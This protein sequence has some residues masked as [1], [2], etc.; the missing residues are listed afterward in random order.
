MADVLERVIDFGSH[1]VIWIGPDSAEKDG[2]YTP[3][4]MLLH[5]AIEAADA[6]S[7]LLRHG[8]VDAMGLHI[9]SQ[10]EAT[11]NAFYILETDTERRGKAYRF[12]LLKAE[13]V[14][15]ERL[16]PST[17]KGAAASSKMKRDKVVGSANL[18]P[19]ANLLAAKRAQNRTFLDQSIYDE[20]RQEWDRQAA[21][22]KQKKPTWHSL[23]GGPTSV[24]EMADRLQLSS[25]YE[26][27][28]P[29]SEEVHASTAMRSVRRDSKTNRAR[30]RP[31][32]HPEL[33]SE[34]LDLCVALLMKLYS[35]V[36]ERFS[37]KETVEL[38]SKWY[39]ESVRAQYDDPKPFGTSD[40][41]REELVAEMSAAFLCGH[42]GIYPVVVANS[43][44][45]I[46][47]WLGILKQDKKLVIS[48]AGQAQRSADWIL[49]TTFDDTCEQVDDVSGQ[50]ASESLS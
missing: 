1:V 16:D 23:F 14:A 6:A 7:V 38:L 34:Y 32:R 49:G 12:G 31:M 37:S 18:T 24:A 30:F 28:R 21:N 48:A 29:L 22:K 33:A 46:S 42:A 15:L 25:F 4:L 8:C 26:F 35:E 13:E 47:G 11:L 27:Y 50:I 20:V 17:T 10:L 5:H 45:Y 36:L 19:D 40:Y 43:T 44:A 39:K 41:G 9:R 3:V 2:S